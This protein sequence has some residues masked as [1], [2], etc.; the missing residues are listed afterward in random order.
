MSSYLEGNTIHLLQH[1]G[2]YTIIIYRADYR[3]MVQAHID[4]L[5]VIE[6][7]SYDVFIISGP[8]PFKPEDRKELLTNAAAVVAK[9]YPEYEQV[10]KELGWTMFNSI[11]RVY[12]SEKAQRILGFTPKYSFKYNLENKFADMFNIPEREFPY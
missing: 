11:D 10:Y 9:Y 7:I 8:T 1:Y 4:A 3:D 5:N 12:V 2:A 6:S